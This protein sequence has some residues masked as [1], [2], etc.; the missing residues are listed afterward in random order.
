MPKMTEAQTEAYL[1]HRLS[2]FRNAGILDIET[3]GLERGSPIHEV[4]YAIPGV[5]RAYQ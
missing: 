4:G 2:K 5:R 3:M 1:R